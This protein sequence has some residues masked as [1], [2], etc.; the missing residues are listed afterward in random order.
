M[1]HFSVLVIARV[2]ASSHPPFGHPNL[3]HDM[4]AWIESE[5]IDKVSWEM[6]NCRENKVVCILTPSLSHT[7]TQGTSSEHENHT[8]EEIHQSDYYISSAQD[9][10]NTVHENPNLP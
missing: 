8:T 1:D 6:W 4:M 3:H 7:Y 2:L 5:V 9:K 10:D